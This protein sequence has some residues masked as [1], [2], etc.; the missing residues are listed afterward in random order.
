[1]PHVSPSPQVNR[2]GQRNR[3]DIKRVMNQAIPRDDLKNAFA[4]H[5][6]NGPAHMGGKSV[7]HST[8]VKSRQTKASRFKTPKR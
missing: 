8:N 7:L 4:G 5:E 2:S 6:N 3:K 1:M